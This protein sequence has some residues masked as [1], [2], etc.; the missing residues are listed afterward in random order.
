MEGKKYYV[1]KANGTSADALLTIGFASFLG[2]L[3]REQYGTQDGIFLQ[4]I[5]PYHSI[6]LPMPIEVNGLM[7]LEKLSIVLPLDSGK[8]REKQAKKGNSPIDGFDYDE[9]MAISRSY[10]EQVKKL[11]GEL[12][13]PEARL[14]KAP[15]LKE[16]TEPDSRLG[17]YQA[18]SQ[19]KIAGTFNDLVQQW[20]RLTTEQKRLHINLLLD[21]FDRPDNDVTMAV[22]IWQK[23][24]KEYGFSGKARVS[25][26]QIINPTTGKGANREK[27]GELTIGN[28]DSFWLLE[29]LKFRGFM[30]AAAP[31]AI[32]ES[33]DRK[34]Y[35]LQPKTIELSLLQNMM[36]AFRAVFWPTTAV[37][38]DIMASL[39][40]AQVFV[41]EYKILLQQNAPL[42]P[43]E[44]KQVGSLAQGFEVIFYKYLG[45][46][47]ATMNVATIGLPIWLPK[48]DTLEQVRAAE[49][50]LIEHVQLIQQ[51]RNNKGEEGAEEYELLRCYRDFL[52]GH[53]LTPFWKF[54][55]AYSSYLISAREKKRYVQQLTTNGLERLIM[56]NRD[57]DTMLI[58]IIN[59]TG[60]QNI[61][62]AIRQATV[63]AQYQR[64]KKD[65]RTYEVRYGLG[66]DLM[67]KA[68]Y[69]ADFMKALCEFVLQY[70][71]ETARE[72]E[73]A[74][75]DR[76]NESTNADARMKQDRSPRR[77]RRLIEEDDMQKVTVLVNRFGS[78]LVGS[79][80]VA[81]GYTF[82]S[83]KASRGSGSGIGTDAI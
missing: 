69:R 68:R 27:A 76:Q 70:N 34:T 16:L 36:A 13:T 56:N 31:L 48:L 78:D 45:S 3:H 74:A 20:D 79:M 12:Q 81:F 63:N 21:L 18:I 46:A 9:Q 26:L 64:A 32:R 19:M 47:H 49:E 41:E 24:A 50:L 67:R 43:W 8:Q 75:R 38:L 39:R 44:V 59:D 60:F 4:D 23:L 10:R 83:P 1:G 28:Q 57:N 35:V 62:E 65:D 30:E 54:T 22:T 82:N 37:K 77:L 17:H 71:T 11:A 61:A 73:R 80:L 51:I 72:I 25:A 55:R 14:R 7:G 40:F 66:Q 33:D 15:E 2:D 6:S 58:E 53:D 42:E 5:G 29:L 52:S